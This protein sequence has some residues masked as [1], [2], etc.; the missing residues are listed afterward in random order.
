MIQ[1]ESYFSE[2]LKPPTRLIGCMDGIY[3]YVYVCICICMYVHHFVD[4]WVIFRIFFL[5]VLLEYPHYVF[6]DVVGVIKN[7]QKRM[8]YVHHTV[9]IPESNWFA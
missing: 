6:H 7:D 3:I 9:W 2:G 4:V 8:A 5:S 1:S